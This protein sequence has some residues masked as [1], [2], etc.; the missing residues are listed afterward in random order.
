MGRS[1]LLKVPGFNLSAGKFSN[2]FEVKTALRKLKCVH[3]TQK[4]PSYKTQFMYK[5]SAALAFADSHHTRR[6]LAVMRLLLE[7]W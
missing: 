6:M 5:S 1:G 7:R 4:C 3:A 2:E